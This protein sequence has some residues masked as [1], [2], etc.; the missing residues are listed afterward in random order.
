MNFVLFLQG[1]EELLEKEMLG[2]YIGR[3]TF[4]ILTHTQVKGLSYVKHVK[5]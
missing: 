2:Q 1:L 5:L 3:L 4:K